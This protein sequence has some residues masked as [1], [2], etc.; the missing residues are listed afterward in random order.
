[1]SESDT[2]GLAFTAAVRDTPRPH[3]LRSAERRGYR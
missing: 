3:R 2:V 1:M